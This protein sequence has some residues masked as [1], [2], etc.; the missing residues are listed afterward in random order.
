MLRLQDRIPAVADLH[1]FILCTRRS[2][3]SAHPEKKNEVRSDS[4]C[5]VLLPIRVNVTRLFLR[6]RNLDSVLNVINICINR[7]NINNE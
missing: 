3:G 2:Q 5:L 6:L 4:G 1:R 7:C